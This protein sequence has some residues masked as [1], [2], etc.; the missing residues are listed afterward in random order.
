MSR[1]IPQD[2]RERASRVTLVLM[3]ADGVMTD[4]RIITVDDGR[5]ARAY[6]ARDGLAVRLGQAA[7][8]AFGVVSGRRSEAV[9]R[10]A[11]ELDYVEIHQG[12]GDKGKLV[13]EIAKRRGVPLD[14]ICFIGDDIVDVPAFRRCGLAIAPADSDPEVFPRVHWVGACEGGRGIVRE[15]VGLIL[16]ARGA[17]ERATASYLGT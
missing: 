8:L 7:G 10:R 17:W 3:D 13:E 16:R 4:G 12:V 1:E 15:A 6:H 14:A 2:V 9:E 11:Q 5:D